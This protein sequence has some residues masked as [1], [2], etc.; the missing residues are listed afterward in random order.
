MCHAYAVAGAAHP[1]GRDGAGPAGGPG[2][3]GAPGRA[4]AA[5]PAAGRGHG[6][7]RGA[8]RLVPGAGL[9]RASTTAALLAGG[10]SG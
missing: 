9:P 5:V 6:A 2:G 3:G 1:A 7:L 8:A 4:G 10:I